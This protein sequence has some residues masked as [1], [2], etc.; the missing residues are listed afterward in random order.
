MNVDQYGQCIDENNNID[1]S[2][3]CTTSYECIDYIYEKVN[4]AVGL[5]SGLGN[6]CI[7]NDGCKAISLKEL[8]ENHKEEFYCYENGSGSQDQSCTNLQEC[9]NI[10]KKHACE[11]RRDKFQLS[12]E[13][14]SCYKSQS[15]QMVK[16]GTSCLPE[17]GCSADDEVCAPDL[18]LNITASI[19]SP[20][21]CS[22]QGIYANTSPLCSA[23]KTQLQRDWKRVNDIA[24]AQRKVNT[25]QATNQTAKIDLQS[26]SFIPGYTNTH[27]PSWGYLG[28]L[29]GALPSDPM[30]IWGDC[31]PV[32]TSST[33]DSY[34]CWNAAASSFACPAYAQVYEY[35]FNTSTGDYLFHAPME[36]FSVDAVTNNFTGSKAPYIEAT[37]WSNDRWCVGQEKSSLPG[38]CGDGVVNDGEQC[39]PKNYVPQKQSCSVNGGNNNGERFITCSASC[40]IEEND[41]KPIA[42]CGNGK[43]ET[44]ETCDDGVNN[45]KYGKCDAPGTVGNDSSTP[46]DES[47]G[48]RSIGKAAGMCGDGEI[49]GTNEFC[50]VLDDNNYPSAS[51]VDVNGN[52]VRIECSP[53]FYNELLT[54]LGDDTCTNA[55]LN[56]INV[57]NLVLDFVAN[58]NNMLSSYA[59]ELKLP[60]AC[61]TMSGRCSLDNTIACNTNQDCTTT[62]GILSMKTLVQKIG[63]KQDPTKAIKNYVNSFSSATTDFGTCEKTIK[64]GSLYHPIK[65]L[66]C[67][68]DC[69]TSGGYCGDGIKQQEEA[70]D[71]GN[72]TN[73]DGCN[74]LCQ[75]ENVACKLQNPSITTGTAGNQIT[76]TI[77]IGSSQSPISQCV[78][79]NSTGEE[80]CRAYGLSC[81]GVTDSGTCSI[82]QS[83]TFG[84]CSYTKSCIK[85]SCDAPIS[86][87]LNSIG[88]G[89]AQVAC[90]GTYQTPAGQSSAGSQNFCGDGIV[91]PN[92]ADNNPNTVEDN[93]A[94]DLGDKNGL[95]CN[96]EYGKSCTY[97]SA[98]CRNILT[99][100]AK[101]YCG[102]GQF[103][104]EYEACD[105]EGGKIVAKKSLDFCDANNGKAIGK[106]AI[107]DYVCSNGVDEIEINKCTDK[108]S[109]SCNECKAVVENC[110]VC[111]EKSEVNGGQRA[112]VGVLNVMSAKGVK[113]TQPSVPFFKP[114]I[115]LWVKKSGQWTNL[116]S[117]KELISTN[118]TSVENNVHLGKRIETNNLCVDSY[119]LSTHTVSTMADAEYNKPQNNTQIFK[120]PVSG[121]V[122]T[123][124]NP[125]IVSPPV[126]QNKLRIVIR[127]PKGAGEFVGQFY[128]TKNGVE[129]SIIYPATTP[130]TLCKEMLKDTA[131]T[132]KPGGCSSLES[133][134]FP[135]TRFVSSDGY[136]TQF[137]AWTLHYNLS[138]SNNTTYA[139]LVQS[140]DGNPIAAYKNKDV[141]VEVYEHRTGQTADSVYPP[142]K[143]FRLKNVAGTSSN[144]LAKFWHVFTIKKGASGNYSIETLN[145]VLVGAKQ[146]PAGLYDGSIETNLCWVKENVKELQACA[147]EDLG[148][149]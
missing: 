129:K 53:N 112:N 111:G 43:I 102:D 101:Q 73:L 13:A 135:H 31:A 60:P 23:N 88:I 22:I 91:N 133:I 63:D 145:N 25:Y 130:S 121:Q 120:Y 66:S 148:A 128:G 34:T 87:N 116:V 51:V 143:V 38:T 106:S 15:G 67:S 68:W 44:G 58:N 50:E 146:V 12:S 1:P 62:G 137:Q 90:A 131:E 81:L 141:V 2:K 149:N 41:C 6:A 28:S 139:F 104:P 72:N 64:T 118:V 36:Y 39:D 7:N 17:A 57:S 122:D 32:S 19:L 14:Y 8:F 29:V 21:T 76:T 80:I 89:T 98:D 136:N 119:I 5:C 4:G 86:D 144:S 54:C 56:K 92:G 84:I 78:E 10:D 105:V 99:V 11:P 37:K 113:W 46:V 108:G 59:N 134:F 95:S 49:N 77:N 132:W 71:D 48:C 140:I 45:G 35:S 115:D 9:Y 30:N 3:N 138:G 117:D 75:K 126:A 96:P 24:T 100:D 97:C 107:L 127:A 93:E 123:V 94:C 69:Q 16:T 82:Q 42:V 103:Q 85:I 40:A 79:N 142:T 26:G 147:T 52:N 61:Y 114:K 125:L 70:C 33:P 47:L 83:C 110:V 109:V 27:W 55:L 20:G 18:S 124:L 65:N 74:N